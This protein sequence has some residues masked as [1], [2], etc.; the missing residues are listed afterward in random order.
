MVRQITFYVNLIA[1][2]TLYQKVAIGSARHKWRL[3]LLNGGDLM[4][5]VAGVYYNINKLFCPVDNYT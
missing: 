3:R 1:D 4:S 2:F 5:G